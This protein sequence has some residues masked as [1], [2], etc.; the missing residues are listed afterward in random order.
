MTDR[1][2]NMLIRYKYV[3]LHVFLLNET[4]FLLIGSLLVQKLW[5]KVF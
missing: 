1:I 5:C 2:V 3:I 4:T